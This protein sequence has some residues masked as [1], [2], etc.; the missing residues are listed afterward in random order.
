MGK[1]KRQRGTISEETLVRLASETYA[2]SIP[3][4]SV[5]RSPLSEEIVKVVGL[6]RDGMSVTSIQ[7]D[8]QQVYDFQFP[9]DKE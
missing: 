6:R 1:P 3:L 8:H 2:G 7:D 9:Q 4:Y 5:L